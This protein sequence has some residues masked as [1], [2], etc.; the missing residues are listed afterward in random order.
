MLG[1]YLGSVQVLGKKECQPP[2]KSIV[3]KQETV[4]IAVYSAMKNMANLKLAY[5]VWKPATSSDSAS[6][7]SKGARLVSATAALKKQKKPTTCGK[8]FQPRKP[9]FALPCARMMSLRLKVLAIKRT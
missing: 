8:M 5:S 4:I 6:G 1:M 9:H 2:K 3:A 7:R